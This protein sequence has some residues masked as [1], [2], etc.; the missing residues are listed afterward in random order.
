MQ[1]APVT[2]LV[3]GLEADRVAGTLDSSLNDLRRRVQGSNFGIGLVTAQAVETLRV[4]RTPTAVRNRAL[5]TGR[6]FTVKSGQPTMI[7]VATP[8]DGMGITITAANGDEP[9]DEEEIDVATHAWV[10]VAIPG[11]GWWGIDP[12][13]QLVAGERHVKIGHGRDYEDVTPLRGVYHGEAESGGLEVGVRM[14]RKG[15]E[16]HEITPRPAYEPHETQQQQ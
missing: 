2:Q 3:L 8:Y 9:E 4:S 6:G 5:N 1:R 12:T 16:H 7:Q 10:E 11:H 14:G 13:N 15:L